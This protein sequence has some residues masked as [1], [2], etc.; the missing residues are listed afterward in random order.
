MLTKEE[1]KQIAD[2]ILQQLGG[3]KFI[4]MT[5]AKNFAFGDAGELT[6]KIGRNSSPANYVKVELNSMDTY[7]MTFIRGTIKGIKD[8]KTIDGLYF[9]M[10]QSEFTAFT[11]LHTSL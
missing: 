2:T 7:T 4:A 8:L 3:N 6:F 10:L 5:G 1:R 11:G 9:D